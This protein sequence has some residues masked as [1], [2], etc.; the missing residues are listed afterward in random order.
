MNT[1][2][3]TSIDLGFF[4]PRIMAEVFDHVKS[5]LPADFL[6]Q[7]NDGLIAGHKIIL[8]A[9]S[10]QLK[11]SSSINSVFSP[12]Y[13]FSF[14]SKF[15][16]HLEMKVCQKFLFLEFQVK[17]FRYSLTSST[18]EKLTLSKSS[19]KESKKRLGF[20]MLPYR[21]LQIYP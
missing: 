21:K 17:M 11:V 12:L 18:M 2:E 3:L 14:I 19:S 15:S 16:L 7:T 5:K 1:S 10:P 8:A 6:L 9:A 4:F 13:Y 20:S